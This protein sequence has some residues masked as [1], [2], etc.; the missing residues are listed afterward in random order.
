M[1]RTIL[2]LAVL[3]LALPAG[4]AEWTLLPHPATSGVAVYAD[5]ATERLRHTPLVGLFVR[6]PVQAWFLTDYAVPHR[7]MVHDVR[8]AKHWVEFD[9]KRAQ[10]RVLARLY[11]A[12]PM[13]QGRAV[14]GETE[15]RAFMPVVPGE[16]EET[17]YQSACGRQQ[18]QEQQ[19]RAAPAAA[20]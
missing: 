17:A 3:A 19:A 9:C 12:E 16:P 11:Y 14:A 8:S 18:A 20:D 13:A 1:L 6:N 2:R 10:M 4:A 5:P 7:W 15:A